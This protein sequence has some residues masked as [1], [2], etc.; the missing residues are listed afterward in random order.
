MDA[1][2]GGFSQKI[3]ES[4]EFTWQELNKHSIKVNQS[5]DDFKTQHIQDYTLDQNKVSDKL[6][7]THNKMLQIEAYSTLCDEQIENKLKE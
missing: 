6:E 5:L 2:K 7:S 1:Q 3:D 4:K